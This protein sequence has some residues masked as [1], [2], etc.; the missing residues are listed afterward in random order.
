MNTNSLK[1]E[2]NK[3]I[4]DLIHHKGKTVKEVA[5]MYDRTESAICSAVNNEIRYRRLRTTKFYEIFKKVDSNSNDSDI[6]YLY[7]HLRNHYCFE[8]LYGIKKVYTHD[9]SRCSETLINQLNLLK[10]ESINRGIKF[11]KDPDNYFKKVIR[12]I[13]GIGKKYTDILANIWFKIEK[14][15]K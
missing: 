15:G 13:T 2:R 8:S 3:E 4:F 6:M 14:E 10:K 5:K 1:E 12:N 9:W 7:L 11:N